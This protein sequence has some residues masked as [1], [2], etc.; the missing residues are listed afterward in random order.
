MR[1]TVAVA[2]DVRVTQEVLEA[3]PQAPRRGIPAAAVWALGIGALVILTVAN[4]L[5][6]TDFAAR[7]IEADALIT[8]V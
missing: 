3:V 2:E 1:D 6:I 8:A 5:A 4:V 7:T